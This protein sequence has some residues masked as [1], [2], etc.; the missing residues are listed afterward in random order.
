M[1]FTF[2]K[3]NQNITNKQVNTYYSATPIIRSL[4]NKKSRVKEEKW[5]EG[6][7]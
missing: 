6:T 4:K 1:E 3:R 2:Q 7:I 5:S